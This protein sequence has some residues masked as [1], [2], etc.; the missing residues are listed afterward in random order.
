MKNIY[1]KWLLLLII[2]I[3]IFSCNKS[4]G[5]WLG[6]G[7]SSGNTYVFGTQTEIESIMGLSKAYSDKNSEELHKYYS[8]DFWNDNQRKKISK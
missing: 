4:G 5:V 8:E 7:D 2:T 6:E 3:F 1:L